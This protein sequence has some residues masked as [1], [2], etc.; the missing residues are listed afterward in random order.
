[1]EMTEKCNQIFFI[2]QTVRVYDLEV[3]AEGLGHWLNPL[4]LSIWQKKK[5]IKIK[6][7]KLVITQPK[8]YLKK[9]CL[10]YRAG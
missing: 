9:L 7:A 8:S 10:A 6:A 5:L 3:T 4:K 1:M 2:S